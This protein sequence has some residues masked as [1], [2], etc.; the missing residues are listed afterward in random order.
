[1]EFKHDLAP[2][3]YYDFGPCMCYSGFVAERLVGEEDHL[4]LIA[5]CCRG[6]AIGRL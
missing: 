1:M 5:F 3:L 2:V 4:V 6:V